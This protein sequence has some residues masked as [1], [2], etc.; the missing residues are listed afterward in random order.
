MN[1]ARHNGLLVTHGY[2]YICISIKGPVFL[3]QFC[4][5]SCCAVKILYFYSNLLTS[6]S[7]EDLTGSVIYSIQSVIIQ[8]L[9]NLCNCF[10]SKKLLI[11]V[12]CFLVDCFY[13]TWHGGF[14][15]KSCHTAISYFVCFSY[16]QIQA[17]NGGLRIQRVC[18]SLLNESFCDFI[19]ICIFL[20]KCFHCNDCKCTL[21]S[22][23]C[24]NRTGRES[25]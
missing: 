21:M 8:F 6:H 12:L 25:C 4:S 16:K 22:K 9:Y 23:R 2:S 10:S 13:N 15:H 7:C 11:G 14:E 1:K 5:T 18:T 3:N 19:L 20:E 17:D 24:V